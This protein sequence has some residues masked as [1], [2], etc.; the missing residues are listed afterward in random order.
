M[1]YLRA[2][3]HMGWLARLGFNFIGFELEPQYYAIAQ[4]RIQ[5]IQ[6]QVSMFVYELTPGRQ[7][8]NIRPYKGTMKSYI[9]IY[10]NRCKVD[11]F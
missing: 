1:I 9:S 6:A 7:A 4:A 2:A 10:L 3:G 11:K 5:A 8:E